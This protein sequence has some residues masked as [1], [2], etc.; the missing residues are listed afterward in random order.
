MI[1]MINQKAGFILVAPY[2]NLI[3]IKF[4]PFQVETLIS[5]WR[6]LSNKLF[7]C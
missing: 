2:I 1:M 6:Y 3:K 5:S 7:T 4:K